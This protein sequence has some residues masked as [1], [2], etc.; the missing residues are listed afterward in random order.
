LTVAFVGDR[1]TRE[2]LSGVSL[3]VKDGEVLA[4]SA[5]LGSGKSILLAAICSAPATALAGAWR[6]VLARRRDLLEQDEARLTALRGEELA[7]AL[8]NPRQHLNPI[9][10]I[11]RQLDVIRAHRPMASGRAAAVDLLKAVN[12]PD[13]VLRLQ[14]YPHELSGGMC[15][16][17]ILALHRQR[18][19]APRSLTSR[20]AAST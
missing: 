6:R 18:A 4:S 9:L 14:A 12:I 2:V 19:Q 7:L 13:P 20:R 1:A 15:Q 17:V 8:S 11:G 5:S 16:R 10:T 3:S